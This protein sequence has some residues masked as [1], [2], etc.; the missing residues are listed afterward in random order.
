[1]SDRDKHLGEQHRSTGITIREFYDNNRERLVVELLAGEE[2]MSRLLTSANIHRP[3]LALAG[4]LDLYTFDRIQVLGNTE[5]LYLAKL[6]GEERRSALDTIFQ[7]DLPCVV[8]SGGKEPPQHL[9]KLAETNGVPL[10]ASSLSTARLF[11][12]AIACLDE[13][14]AMRTQ[15]HA[16]LVDVYGVGLLITGRS[17][18]GKS[19]IA[20]DLVERGH[21][22]V[23]DD[24]VT[25]TRWAKGMLI[26]SANP[27]LGH[28]MEIRGLG[29]IAVQRLFGIRSIRH[30][31]RVEVEVHLEEW[32]ESQDY[33]RLGLDRRSVSLLDVEI[34]C[35]TVPIYP[36]KNIT[37]IAEVIA[38]DHLL[39][40]GGVDTAQDFAQAHQRILDSEAQ[41]GPPGRGAAAAMPGDGNQ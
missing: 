35:V 26:G 17:G 38:M 11:H 2:G 28:H 18:I 1:M 5:L 25:V 37:V 31:K 21:R 32:E 39:Q 7:F 20:L 36:G 13:A 23:A 40:L 8:V 29:I 15:V 12:Q 33:D 27:T 24:V 30:H 19:E 10:F 41:G 6:S 9:V 34:S 22:L 14:F 3:S 4:I 16:S